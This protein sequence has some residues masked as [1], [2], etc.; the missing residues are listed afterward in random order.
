MNRFELTAPIIG[1]TTRSDPET[2]TWA[3]ARSSTPYLGPTSVVISA[4]ESN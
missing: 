4:P 1:A 3:L 2:S